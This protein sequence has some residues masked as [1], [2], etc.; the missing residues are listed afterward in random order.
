MS[1]C[2]FQDVILK[3]IIQ[4]TVKILGSPKFMFPSGFIGRKILAHKYLDALYV[5]SIRIGSDMTKNYL[6]DMGLQNFFM[7]FDEIHLDGLSNDKVIYFNIVCRL[8]YLTT[9]DN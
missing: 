9:P 8:K 2:I 4:P 1:I 6:I 5:I 7:V 3:N